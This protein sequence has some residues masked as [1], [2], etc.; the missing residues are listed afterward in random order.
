MIPVVAKRA[1]PTAFD[2]TGDIGGVAF[3]PEGDLDHQAAEIAELC[4]RKLVDIGT[5]QTSLL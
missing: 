2:A 5:A 3:D 4:A 1:M